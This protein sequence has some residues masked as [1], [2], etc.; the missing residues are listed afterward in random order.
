M[1]LCAYLIWVTATQ[2]DPSALLC[3]ASMAE[4]LWEVWLAC[5]WLLGKAEGGRHGV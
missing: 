2:E 1:I 4:W 3:V 5:R